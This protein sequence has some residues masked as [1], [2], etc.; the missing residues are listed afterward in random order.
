[1]L[2]LILILK[3]SAREDSEGRL[4]PRWLRGGWSD[5]TYTYTHTHTFVRGGSEAADLKAGWLGPLS[6]GSSVL[7]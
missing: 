7:G 2:M 4:P 6:F 3:A 1:M 5:Y